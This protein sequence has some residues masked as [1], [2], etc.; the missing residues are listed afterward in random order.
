MTVPRR[1]YHA[2]NWHWWSKILHRY[3]TND[4]LPFY[5]K[6]IFILLRSKMIALDTGWLP[7]KL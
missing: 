2:N 6:D 4:T 3:P 1:H 5:M 7:K